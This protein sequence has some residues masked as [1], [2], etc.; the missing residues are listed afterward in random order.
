MAV[1]RFIRHK[2]SGK[3]FADGQWLSESDRA[4]QFETLAAAIHAAVGHHLNGAQVVL[5]IG[6][7]PSPDYDIYFDLTDHGAEQDGPP[8][9]DS[10]S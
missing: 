5:Q 6:D 3:Y 1:K 8:R 7:Q 9:S 10:L 2:A 4:Q